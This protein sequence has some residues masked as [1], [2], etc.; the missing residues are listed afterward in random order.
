MPSFLPN[1]CTNATVLLTILLAELFA[2]VLALSDVQSGF[3][4]RL[5]LI[6]LFV[7]WVVLG[8]AALLCLGRRWLAQLGAVATTGAVIAITQIVTLGCSLSAIYFFNLN[9]SSSASA[10][11]MRN[12]AIAGI[13]A[14]V[15]LRYFY[16]RYAWREQINAEARA[17]LQALQARIHPHF[18][19][20]TL[21]TIASLIPHQP[22]DAEQ[23]VL[24][25]A[26][27]LRSALAE[28]SSI[29]LAEEVALTR[30]YLAI[31]RLRMGERLVVDWQL[32]EPLPWALPLPPL[33]LQPL[34][35][36][37]N[38]HGLQALANGWVLTL[39]L[40]RHGQA[41]C[42]TISNPC[43]PAAA[44]P[45]GQ[46][47]AQENIRQRLLLAYP[48]AAPLTIRASAGIYQVSF[49]IPLLPD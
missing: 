2:I 23:A 28:R 13:I 4:M 15:S 42:C 45:L 24:D 9:L 34:V 43:A 12:L 22:A 19:F 18:L 3:W 17:R 10:F 38:R 39:R 36:N 6:S 44:T 29:P 21:N 11:I 32:V 30:R 7:Q 35:E 41:L 8:S 16:V 46:H 20:N 26:D 25:L 31:E 5:A 37:A 47:M 1:F 49:S 33:I 48:L 14:L 27:L 40:A